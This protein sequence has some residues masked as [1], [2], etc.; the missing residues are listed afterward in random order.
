MFIEHPGLFP[1][2]DEMDICPPVFCN[3][4]KIL[5]YPVPGFQFKAAQFSVAVDTVY[6]VIFN[7]RGINSTMKG[8]SLLFTDSCSQPDLLS[9]QG[10]VIKFYQ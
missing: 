3:S 4:G 5:P 7:D 1:M 6:E 9:S 10:F 2:L 8:I